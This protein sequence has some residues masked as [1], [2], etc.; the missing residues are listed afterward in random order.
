MNLLSA[1]FANQ[2]QQLNSN[3]QKTDEQLQN[4]ID[5]FITEARMFQDVIREEVTHQLEETL[6]TWS[7]LRTP[8]RLRKKQIQSSVSKRLK[9]QGVVHPRAQTY[10]PSAKHLNLNLNLIIE[11]P[12]ERS[13]GENKIN[14]PPNMSE[15][16]AIT[17]PTIDFNS[18]HEARTY[19]RDNGFTEPCNSMSDNAQDEGAMDGTPK[20]I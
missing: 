9:Q 10:T 7:L 5:T 17:H 8:T 1:E 2:A 15:Q 16:G 19:Q 6:R 11:P 18:T 12:E 20:D 4:R 13:D 14:S 3:Q